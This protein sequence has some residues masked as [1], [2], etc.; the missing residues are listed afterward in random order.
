MYILHVHIYMYILY[1][2]I[3]LYVHITC[4][5][6]FACV[7]TIHAKIPHNSLQNTPKTHAKMSTLY[8][9]NSRQNALTIHAKISLKLLQLTPKFYQLTPK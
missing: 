7:F 4:T 3:D 9:H 6:W 1:A 5:Y 8:T 2:H